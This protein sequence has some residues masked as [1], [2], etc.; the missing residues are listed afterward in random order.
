MNK[1]TKCLIVFLAV[2]VVVVFASSALVSCSSCPH[3]KGSAECFKA[4]KEGKCTC[5]QKCKCTCGDKCKCADCPDD[6]TG[7]DCKCVCKGKHK[8]KKCPHKKNKQ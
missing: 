1:L 5:G 6:C 3:K 7:K 4:H 2:L 8:C